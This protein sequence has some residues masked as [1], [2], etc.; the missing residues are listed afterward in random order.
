MTISHNFWQICVLLHTKKSSSS[1]VTWFEFDFDS[2]RVEIEWDL[3]QVQVKFQSRVWQVES[4]LKIEFET[5]L[6]GQFNYSKSLFFSK[7]E[8]NFNLNTS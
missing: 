7:F 6:D 8:S 5:W 4:S 3:T 1:Q 2:S